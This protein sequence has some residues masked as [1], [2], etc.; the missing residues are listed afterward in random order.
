MSENN[1][2]GIDNENTNENMNDMNEEMSKKDGY[3]SINN[4]DSA[5]YADFRQSSNSINEISNE[6]NTVHNTYDRYENNNTYDME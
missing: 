1:L 3:L 6:D 5:G 4:Y 2:Y